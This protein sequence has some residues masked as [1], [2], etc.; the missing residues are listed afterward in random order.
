MSSALAGAVSELDAACRAEKALS[1]ALAV[2]L[3]FAFRPDGLR[4]MR[5]RP[6]GQYVRAMS[7]MRHG[8]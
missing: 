8:L 6:D 2:L 5:I 3:R 1:A 4:C 7:R